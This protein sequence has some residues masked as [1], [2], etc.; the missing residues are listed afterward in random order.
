MKYLLF[1]AGVLLAGCRTAPL[2]PAEPR[3]I[4]VAPP[5]PTPA[6]PDRTLERKLRQQAQTIEA[7]ISQNDALTAQLGQAPRP[8][9][10]AAR[11]LPATTAVTEAAKPEPFLSP[12]ADG[13]IDLTATDPDKGEAVNPFVVRKVPT[14]ATREVA[15][16]VGGII[17][18]PTK[19]AVINDR[20]V[21]TGEAIESLTVERIEPDAVF[22]RREGQRLRLPVSGSTVRVR[23][24]L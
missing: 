4:V 17:A 5:S 18:G 13:V 12:N 24:A 10:P 7:L 11:V 6:E 14:E 15:L 1:F 8:I 9:E 16:H 21:Q 22:L 20:L 2:P 23:M 3:P 19:C